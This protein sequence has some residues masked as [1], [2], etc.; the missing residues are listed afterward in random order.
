MTDNLW[1]QNEGAEIAYD[2]EGQGPLLVL[3]VGGNGDSSRYAALSKIL[4]S[5]YTVLRYDRRASFRSTG[6]PDADIALEQHARDAAALIEANGGK[7]LVFG[8][9]GG[10]SIAIKLTES[11]PQMVTALIAHEPPVT[12]I[13]PDAKEQRAFFDG[14]YSTFLA[15]GA[16][17][18]MA[19]FVSSFEGV[20]P[21]LPAPPDQGGNSDHFFKHEFNNLNDY[22][23]DITKLRTD[24]VPIVMCAGKKSGQAFYV[25]TAREMSK[26]LGCEYV[27]VSGHH[28]SFVSDPST[29]AKELR[30]ILSSLETAGK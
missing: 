18:A 14:V 15:K 7:A 24:G 5:D 11:F 9:S 23:P 16:G 13:L 21:N 29:F 6:D 4:S 30:T 26:L 22:T 2:L 19:V 12:N 8:N 3:I 28:I 17:P 1:L 10:A 20:D 27:E 25:R